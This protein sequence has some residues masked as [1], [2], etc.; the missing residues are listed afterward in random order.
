MLLLPHIQTAAHRRSTWWCHHQ[1]PGQLLF[2]SHQM[3]R[4]DCWACFLWCATL[5]EALRLWA[6]ATL[7][8]TEVEKEN[9]ELIII[10]HCQFKRSWKNY[11]RWQQVWKRERGWINLNT[12]LS[13]STYESDHTYILLRAEETTLFMFSCVRAWEEFKACRR[14]M[15][16][17]V[18]PHKTD[19]RKS[20]GTQTQRP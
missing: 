4:S 2:R 1:W 17:R 15:A 8:Q 7:L 3:G 13:K 10:I 20:T 16:H 14:Q 11:E 9:R 5:W 18:S 12:S 6:R 19:E